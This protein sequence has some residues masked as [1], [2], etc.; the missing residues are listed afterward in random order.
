MKRS[1]VASA[2]LVFV[3]SG[4]AN[5]PEPEP[6][7]LTNQSANAIK[8]G[9]ADFDDVNVVGMFAMN[10]GMCSGTLIAPNLVL[11][12]RHCVSKLTPD[13]NGAVQ[14]GVS[15]FGATYAGTG[16][17]VSTDQALS[18]KGNWFKGAEVRVPED[19][20]GAC[21]YD[22]ALLI[23]SEKVDVTP[24]VPRIDVPATAGEPYTAVGYGQQD[25]NGGWSGGTRMVL[26]GL[27]VVCGA[28]ECP[29]QSIEFTEFLGDT[30]ICQGDSGGPALDAAGKVIGVV[31]RGGQGCTTPIYGSVSSW[32]DFIIK[33]ALDAA[34]QGGYEPPFWA[35]TG[36]SDPEQQPPAGT[37]G[38]GGSSGGNPQGQS[39]GAGQACPTGYQCYAEG[40]VESATCAA[41]C[42]AANPCAGGFECNSLG[43]CSAAAAAPNGNPES[44]SD[45]GGCSLGG[46]RGPAKPVP[47]VFALLGACASLLRRRRA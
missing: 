13:L 11:T 22:V 44:S 41:Q 33:T 37:G 28:G 21:G 36:K 3:F 18:Q 20:T 27:N 5:A 30:G 2:A 29:G 8:G 35:L 42:S 9:A 46:E 12:A 40:P 14:C 19:G 15:Q 16:F 43:V 6:G 25:D 17:F 38:A 34:A 23:L 1:L 31:S 45:S 26:G 39:C 10:G 4:C 47:W 7:T 24:R 32:S